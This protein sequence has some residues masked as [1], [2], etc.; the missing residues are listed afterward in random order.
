V[1]GQAYSGNNSNSVGGAVLNISG[2]TGPYACAMTAGS[3]PSGMSLSEATPFAA[4]AGLCIV[5]GTPTAAGDFIFTVMVTD[6]A[7]NTASQSTKLV[8]E[9]AS[10]PV[11]SNIT[12]TAT[13]PATETITWTTD[14]PAD[15]QVLYGEYGNI[16]QASAI[17]DTGGVISHSVTIPVWPSVGYGYTVISRGV[18]GG[19]PADYEVA[20][21]P[22]D[23]LSFTAGSAPSGGPLAF[24]MQGTGPHNVIQGFPLYVGIYNGFI[25]NSSSL[26]TFKWV[27]TNIPPNTLVHWPDV[28]D[29]G[30]NCGTVSTTATPD[31]TF[32]TNGAPD[33]VGQFSLLTSVG[34]TTPVG[35]YTVTVTVYG[36]NV[37]LAS[38]NWAIHVNTSS[39]TP[40]APTTYPPI[41]ALSTWQ[42]NMTTYGAQYCSAPNPPPD[43]S[44]AWYYDG[45]WVFDQI[46]NYVGNS[47]P[48]KSCAA[49]VKNEYHNYIQ[50]NPRGNG[51]GSFLGNEVFPDGL[52]YD[53][54]TNS[55]V[56]SCTDLHD[57]AAC[58]NCSNPAQSMIANLSAYFDP[59]ST[60]EG[61]YMLGTKRADYDAGGGTT[62]AQVKQM[63]AYCLGNVDQAVNSGGFEECFI[64]GLAA[65]ALIDYY[66]DPLTGNGDIRVPPAM[67]AL[68]DHLWTEWLPYDGNGGMFFYMKSIYGQFGSIE[69]NKTDTS[70]GSGLTSLN[71]IIAPLY[72]W[73][74]KMTG[75][76]KYQLEGDQVWAT[77][78]NLP[79]S[80]LLAVTGKN[81]SQTYRWSFDYVKWR[82]GT[83]TPPPPTS[84]PCDV[85]GD[86]VTNV[87][88]V[89]LEVNM[90]LGI[91]PCSNPSG[92]CT[93]VSVQRVV[94]AALG[95][96]CVTP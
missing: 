25:S 22:F 42:S 45:T 65:K 36:D 84:S 91:I 20:F 94:N 51:V 26:A 37:A 92:T 32:T 27:V 71:L 41:P 55:N 64:D 69:M 40:G 39:F 5:T 35:S 73:V 3:L 88:D 77:G 6:S 47:A 13:T 63:A 83:S 67:Q 24:E 85:N 23:S 87:A 82:G 50:S 31:D 76:Q 1:Q 17:Q 18:V 72:A 78:V 44:G 34:G 4:P 96:T 86:S 66:N 12:A 80:D 46:M 28:Q 75:I 2:G 43:E 68:A 14:V 89:Q 38:F 95:G 54:K 52:Y 9:T 60:R 48:W 10:P 74:Y 30:C 61:C 11:I 56:A 15:S 81:F 93:V 90:A 21:T 16:S 59:M 53:C 58:P 7:S 57:I 19:V 62:L 33:N 49:T 8:V 29:D 70:T 79:P